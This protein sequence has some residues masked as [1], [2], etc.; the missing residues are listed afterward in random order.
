MKGHK[1]L[2]TFINGEGRFTVYCRVYPFLIDSCVIRGLNNNND[3]NNNYYYFYYFI[4][5]IGNQVKIE[6]NEQEWLK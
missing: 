4:G 6:L 3:N 1:K 5:F 2:E